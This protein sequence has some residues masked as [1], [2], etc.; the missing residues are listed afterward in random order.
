MSDPTR[1]F[2][3][4]TAGEIHQELDSPK[5]IE[6]LQNAGVQHFIAYRTV[7]ANNKIR[8]ALIE[9]FVLGDQAGYEK[10]ERRL[11]DALMTDSM[12]PAREKDAQNAVSLLG[13]QIEK[14]ARDLDHTLEI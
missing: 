5:G 8:G 3:Q 12:K 7:R 13:A 6:D 1:I 2:K 10:A 11:V 14:I 4:I 9:A